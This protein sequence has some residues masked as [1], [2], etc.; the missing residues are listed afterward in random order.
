M[1][2]MFDYLPYEILSLILEEAAG[3]N[4]QDVVTY[5][6]GLTKAPKPLQHVKLERYI[7]GRKP[8][9]SLRWVAVNSIRQVNST[10][11]DWA[12]GYAVNELYIRGWRGSER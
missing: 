3:L 11:R 1:A 4:A 12:L 7:R 8:E 9:D 10:W 2:S 6:Y 5:T